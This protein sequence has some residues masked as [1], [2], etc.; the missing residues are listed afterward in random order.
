MPSAGELVRLVVDR[1]C[2]LRATGKPQ[3]HE[4]TILAGIVM[5]DVTS[6]V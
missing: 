5:T 1:Y 6:E 4:W 2:A 3:A